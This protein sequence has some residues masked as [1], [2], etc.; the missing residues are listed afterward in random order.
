MYA[1]VVLFVY[2]REEHT[3]LVLDALSHNHGTEKTDLFIYSDA[4]KSENEREAVEGVRKYIRKFSNRNNFRSVTVIEAEENK[5]L[6]KSIIGGVTDVI[7]KYGKIIVLEDDHITAPDFLTYMNSGLD[8][9]E[10]NTLIWSIS[11]YTWKM[12]GFSKYRHDVFMGYRAS[13]WG[14]ASWKDRWEKVQWDVPDFKEFIL[15]KSA[16]QKFNRGGMDMTE[17]LCQQQRG[18]I[19][20]WAIRWCYQQYKEGMLS[21]FPVHS[22][23]KNIGLDGSGTHS[24]K[25]ASFRTE[26]EETDQTVFENLP[27]CKYLALEF[28]SYFSLLYMRQLLGRQ[29]YRLTEYEYCI[30]YRNRK[31][32]KYRVLKPCFWGWYEKPVAFEENGKIYVQAEKYNKWLNRRKVVAAELGKDGRLKRKKFKESKGIRYSTENL[33]KENAGKCMLEKI[34]IPIPAFIYWVWSGKIYGEGSQI[35]VVELY[36]QRFSIGGLL[37]KLVKRNQIRR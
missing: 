26:A 33:Q 25:V 17:M 9:Y 23:V 4:A 32:D 35:E 16:Q 37:F 7:N 22:K 13:C 12:K 21:V 34:K 5:G 15:D 8:F 30:L 10:K 20:S 29:W 19:N 3:R 11:G 6:A 2:N 14:W 36:V 27:V 1:P 18:E 31:D 24:G 28:W